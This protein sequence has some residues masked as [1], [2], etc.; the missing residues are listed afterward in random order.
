MKLLLDNLPSSLQSQR[1]TLARCL[2]A[3]DR[4]LP[5]REVYLFSG[6]ALS[7][8]RPRLDNSKGTKCFCN[9]SKLRIEFRANPADYTRVKVAATKATKNEAELLDQATSSL[10]KAVKQKMLKKQ[11]RVDY[12]KL[13]KDGYS[14]RFLAKLE[15]A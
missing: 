7:A 10:L 11:G 6:S 13:R 5:L 3:M 14:D 15:E 1:E 8:A 12:A 2:E 4:A 9:Q